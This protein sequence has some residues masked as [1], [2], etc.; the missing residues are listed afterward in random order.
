MKKEELLEELVNGGYLKTESIIEAFKFVDRKNF[1]LEKDK[2]SAYENYPL[3]IGYGQTISQPLTV[4][5]MLELLEPRKKE[6]V[7]EI[8]T[9]SGWQTCLLAYLV[10]GGEDNGGRIFS[11]ERIPELKEF[12]NKNIS[13]NYPDFQRYITLIEGDGSLGF[14][15]EAPFDKII[16]SAAAVKIPETLKKQL[17]VGGRMVIPVGESILSLDKI[18][19]DE[20]KTKE[21]FGF[22]FVKFIGAD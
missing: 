7:L 9:G 15:K 13:Q 11:I 10:S 20:F 14:D 16:V 3:S 19:E 21:F 18:S 2:D 8:G 6:K 22:S 1:V 12:A 5:F 4:A 17:K